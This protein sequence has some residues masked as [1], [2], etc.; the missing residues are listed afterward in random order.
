MSFRLRD[1]GDLY[2]RRQPAVRSPNSKI[3]WNNSFFPPTNYSLDCES[4][5]YTLTGQSADLSVSRSLDCLA[6]S[7]TLTGQDADLVY[8]PAGGV[9]YT[10]DCEHGVYSLTGQNATLTY[11]PASTGKS[12]DPNKYNFVFDKKIITKKKPKVEDLQEV[13]ELVIDLTDVASEESAIDAEIQKLQ[14]ELEL[15][16][17]YNANISKLVF[18]AEQQFKEQESRRQKIA[19]LKEKQRQIQ[20]E[21]EAIM[22][23]IADLL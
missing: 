4:G 20:L 7:Y 8:S 17:N 23:L 9:S 3:I 10:L 5:T 6:G 18:D 2:N 13:E 21:D 22:K 14:A 11:T 19:E 1:F 12:H 16:A 15:V